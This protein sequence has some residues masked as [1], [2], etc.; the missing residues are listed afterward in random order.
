MQNLNVLQ[1]ITPTGFYGA[2]RWVLALANNM[3]RHG[4]TCD[5]AVTKEGDTQDLTVAKVYPRDAGQVH[6]LEMTGRFDLRAIKKLC[7]VIRER[8]IHVI[9]THGYKS[10]IIGFLAAKRTGIACVSTPHGFPFKPGLKLATFLRISSFTLRYFD[11]VVPLSEELVLD[12]AALRIPDYKTRYICNG[13]DLKEIDQVL[14][15]LKVAP[16]IRGQK[17]TKAIGYIGR[18]IPL[19]GL[20]DLLSVFEGLYNKSPNLALQMIGDGPQ[21]AELEKQAA[22]QKSHNAISFLGFR[23]DR[24]ELLANLD[25]F[26]MTSSSEGIPRCLMEAMAVGVPVVAYDIPGVDQLV[27]HG[28]TGMLAPLGD[29]AA[30]ELCC[31]EVLENPELALKLVNN[32]RRLIEERYSAARMAKEY[33]SLFKELVGDPK[34]STNHP[35]QVI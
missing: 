28:E 16:Q 26:V 1:F 3:E 14:R 10:D 24:L 33:H 9:H 34:K 17:A 22:A 21:R 5:L 31:L 2:E 15:E 19:K 7:R 20:G 4:I 27:T 12:I 23:S 29:K 35:D 11:A 13:V 8:N 18:L 30:L 32:A 25:L 6:Y